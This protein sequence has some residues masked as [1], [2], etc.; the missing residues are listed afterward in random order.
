MHLESIVAEEEVVI[1]LLDK[2]GEG[3]ATGEK[4]IYRVGSDKTG[5]VE[6]SGNPAWRMKG[7]EGAGGLLV[8]NPSRK[9]FRASDHASLKLL[10]GALLQP[11][12]SSAEPRSQLEAPFSTASPLEIHSQEYDLSSNLITFKGSVQVE[13]P[14]WKLTCDRVTANVSTNGNRIELIRASG[15]VEME[16][17]S[18]RPVREVRTVSKKDSLIP[19]GSEASPWKMTCDEME[20]RMAEAGNQVEEI[21][22][23]GN[24]VAT[25]NEICV[26]GERGIYVPSSETMRLT[27]DPKMVRSD[28]AIVTARVLIL[29][30]RSNTFEAEGN[31]RVEIPQAAL[32]KAAF[33]LPKK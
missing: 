31:F 28:G 19:G 33:T 10:T 24:V 18:V 16:E 7:Y 5:V 32:P 26:T 4:A 1:D 29:D 25:Q 15:K 22:A 9:E 12:S 17:S 23:N 3:Q 30:R 20:L 14:G 27:G 13:Q 2:N 11:G 8:F 6:L 21:E